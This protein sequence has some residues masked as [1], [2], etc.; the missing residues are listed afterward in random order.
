MGTVAGVDHG[1]GRIVP[2]ENAPLP[3]QQPIARPGAQKAYRRTGE[4]IRSPMLIVIQ[5]QRSYATGKSI[6]TKTPSPSIFLPYNFGTPESNGRMPRRKRIETAA[7]R[8]FAVYQ[9]F[10]CIDAANDKQSRSRS[11]GNSLTKR[12]LRLHAKRTEPD[13]GSGRKKT[14]DVLGVKISGLA[15]RPKLSPCRRDRQECSDNYGGKTNPFE[16]K[17]IPR[18]YDAE[19]TYFLLILP[20]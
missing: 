7:V 2:A 16:H 17:Q 11:C 8:P 19:D 18:Q 15:G 5:P 6:S 12:M 10:Q 13:S 14:Q 1:Q 20:R 4:N 9:M 3:R